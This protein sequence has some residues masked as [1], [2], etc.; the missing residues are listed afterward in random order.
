MLEDNYDANSS[1]IVVQCSSLE[2]N[3]HW[4]YLQ[5]SFRTIQGIDY[6]MEKL[7]KNLK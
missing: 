2:P 1:I 7:C 4:Y 3:S 6:I 5:T